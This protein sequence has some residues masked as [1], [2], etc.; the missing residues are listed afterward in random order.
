MGQP[1]PL[2]DGRHIGKVQID[3]AR[4]PDQLG[5]GQQRLP[6]HI[7]GNLET[8]G[9]GNLL[10]GHMLNAVV[11]NNYQGVHLAL[12]LFNAGLRLLHPAAALKPEGLGHHAH[13]QNPHFLG[14]LGHDGGR[15]GA[16]T[17][18][19]AGGDEHHVRVLQGL[20]YLTAALLGGLAAHLRIAAG[21]LSVGQLLANLNLIGG[22]G[23]VEYLLVRID[24]DKIH[25]C[26][27][28][29][30]H[31]VDYVIAAAARTNHLDLY[32]SV[33]CGCQLDCHDG[34]SSYQKLYPLYVI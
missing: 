29:I 23:L 8:V 28:G 6:Q 10:V 33:I 31:T 16:G 13:G 15:A 21:A 34:N 3:E 18:A 2:H 9:K 17:T 32:N 5:N 20:G 1:R 26:H 4:L 25:A 12:Q 19:H 11:G 30:Y 22:Y 7:V 27:A 14:G 24:C